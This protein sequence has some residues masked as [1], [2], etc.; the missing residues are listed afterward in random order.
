MLED[1]IYMLEVFRRTN[2]HTS[3][4]NATWMEITLP[5]ILANCKPEQIY[6][7][8]EFVPYYQT[9]PDRLIHLKK[10]ICVS[11]KEVNSTSVATY[12]LLIFWQPSSE[13]LS[14]ESI[15]SYAVSLPLKTY[16]AVTE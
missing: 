7:A 4:M 9:I 14:M 2:T 10:E 5:T 13:C 16:P 1:L 15:K 3:S 8:D 11:R 12:Q 6:N